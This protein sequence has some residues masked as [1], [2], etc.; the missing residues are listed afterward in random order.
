MAKNDFPLHGNLPDRF[1]VLVVGVGIAG[2]RAALCLPDRFLVG[3]LAKRLYRFLQAI[4]PK[5]GSPP[6]S[7]LTHSLLECL[8]FTAQRVHLKE[9]GRRR[10][11]EQERTS[12]EEYGKV[13]DKISNFTIEILEN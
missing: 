2:V 3:L 10:G 7:P 12:N 1:Y 9:E 4:G 13:R 6:Q 11:N 5:A 8:V